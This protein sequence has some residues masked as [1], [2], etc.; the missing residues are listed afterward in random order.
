MMR[1]VTLL[2]KSFWIRHVLRHQRK[3][4]IRFFS[5]DLHRLPIFV[6]KFFYPK[7]ICKKLAL[8]LKKG[9]S[10]D[11]E[12]VITKFFSF[13]PS[14]P[15]STR[16]SSMRSPNVAPKSVVKL[17]SLVSV[18][19]FANLLTGFLYLLERIRLFYLSRNFT[20]CSPYQDLCPHKGPSP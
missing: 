11:Q 9:I 17:D 12:P 8:P 13:E 15:W 5:F 10:L 2:T 18:V 6:C 4:W 7:V 20:G 1:T 3:Q 16:S 14:R 19:Q